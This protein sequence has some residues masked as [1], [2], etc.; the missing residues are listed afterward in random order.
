MCVRRMLLKDLIN[1]H[2]KSC[3]PF[4]LN[5]NLEGFADFNAVCDVCEMSSK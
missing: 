2:R 3:S 5:P 1:V 4:S